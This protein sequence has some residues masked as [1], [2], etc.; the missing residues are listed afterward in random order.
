MVPEII[1]WKNEKKK[2]FFLQLW[3]TEFPQLENPKNNFHSS[4]STIKIAFYFPRNFSVPLE[5][6]Q[7]SN[8]LIIGTTT[9]RLT[10]G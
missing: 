1:S 8:P 5:E 4:H 6:W 2:L 7:Q 10:K 9:R 3:I